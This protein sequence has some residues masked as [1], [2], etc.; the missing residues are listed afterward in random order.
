MTKKIKLILKEFRR[1]DGIEPIN[2][3]AGTGWR[4][5]EGGCG[6]GCPSCQNGS[7]HDNKP[8]DK[9]DEYGS[10]DGPVDL[11]DDGELSACELKH[12]FDLNHDG[13]VTPD[14]YDSHVNWHCRHPEV[15]DQAM[16]D[17][18]S[19]KNK[20]YQDD[21]EYYVYDD[22]SFEEYE[23]DEGKLYDLNILLEK[24]KKKAKKDRCY[25]LAKRKYKVFP[26]AYASGFIVRCRKGKVAKKRK[27]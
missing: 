4:L 14:E 5:E 9:Y 7:H 6:C 10:S 21:E 18:E 3:Q 12:H 23:L 17:Y 22:E 13:V 19:V 26:S 25:K 15:L 2:I 20:I 1:Q 27:N 16:D 24:R 8:Q 11:D